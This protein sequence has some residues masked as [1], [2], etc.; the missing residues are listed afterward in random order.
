MKKVYF[1][2][3]TVGLAFSGISQKVDKSVIIANKK[4][5]NA[6][7]VSPK[8]TTTPLKAGGDVV[9]SDDFSTPSN[10]VIDNDG[11]VSTATDAYGW[12]IGATEQSWWTSSVI[13]STSD[14]NFAELNNGRPSATT[15]ALDV[16]YTLTTASPI[17]VNALSGGSNNYILEFQQYGARFYEAQEV[18]ISVDNINWTLVGSNNDIEMLTADGGEAYANPTVKTINL[19]G[20]IP[21]GTNSLWIRFS[22]TSEFPTS[23]NANV[24]VAYGWMIDDVRILEA[25]PN[26]FKVS[27][28]FTGDI[29]NNWDYYSIP[30]A[31]AIEKRVGVIISNEGGTAQ[32]KAVSIDITSGGTSVFSG[33]TPSVSYAPGVVDTVWFDTGF[34]PTATGLYTVTATLPADDLP[35]NNSASENFVITNY[36]YGHNHPL[37]T[38]RFAFS[39]EAEIGIGN[40]YEAQADQLLKGIDVAFA[41]GTTGGIFLDVFLYEMVSASVQDPSNN[42]VA[43][44]SIQLPT[45]VNTSTFTTLVFPSPYTMEAGKT[46]YAIVRTSQ[47]ATEKMR[48][49]SSLKGD[50]DFSTVIY[51]PFGTGGGVNNFLGWDAAAAVSLNFDPVL[52]IN[53]ANTPVSFGTI[54]P[55]PTTDE[56]TINYS[57][58]NATDVAVVVVDVT[59]RVMYTAANENKTAGEHSLTVDASAFA[60]G[61]YHVNVITP[62]STVTTK[63]I[64][65]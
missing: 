12:D 19:S 41:T 55:N 65:R 26:E 38:G 6:G 28:V 39:Q 18:Y 32:T 50:A 9:W 44:L 5:A 3:L 15:Q 14:G 58:A 27:T 11:Q 57:L 52:S 35:T 43:D 54:F 8:P 29:V 49:K 23:T 51:G 2:I 30:T 34:T 4:L 36:L 59:G 1:T 63:F 47:T 16:Q 64:K 40:I 46:Y 31:Q 42:I 20:F 21:G 22:W 56:T 25:Y 60:S 33:T 17:D 10:W 62:E 37:G 13:N 53:S 48:V 61:V 45:A 7:Y 24:W